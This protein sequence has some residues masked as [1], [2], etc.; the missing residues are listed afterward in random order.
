MMKSG[1]ERG[2]AGGTGEISRWWNHRTQPRGR[3]S[4][5]ERAREA[6]GGRRWGG[7]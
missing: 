2:R 6:C 5:P 7:L 3:G 1:G 4:R